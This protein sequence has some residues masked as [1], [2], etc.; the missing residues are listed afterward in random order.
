MKE[1]IK[2]EGE[3]DTL[4]AFILYSLLFVFLKGSHA[5][6]TSILLPPPGPQP[7][8]AENGV[9]CLYCVRG[10]DGPRLQHHLS[11]LA[12]GAAR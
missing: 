9:E 8:A 6:V 10:L 11:R 12:S 7:R 2:R 1:E 5:E 3:R 4:F